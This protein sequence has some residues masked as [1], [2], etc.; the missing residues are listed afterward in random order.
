MQCFS[1][2]LFAGLQLEE[3]SVQYFG[4]AHLK[5]LSEEHESKDNEGSRHEEEGS[6]EDCMKQVGKGGLPRMIVWHGCS[7]KGQ[8]PQVRLIA[9]GIDAPCPVCGTPH[10][11]LHWS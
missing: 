10:P 2:W 3:E 1:R 6:E 4:P 8:S 5:R 9:H 7:C 11:V